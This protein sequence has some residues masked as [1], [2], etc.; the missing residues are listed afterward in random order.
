[1]PISKKYRF[2]FINYTIGCSKF[3]RHIKQ[4]HPNNF[5]GLHVCL[6]ELF[7]NKFFPS[8]WLINIY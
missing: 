5:T 6:L 4:K 8:I 7:V 3:F 1:M 2:Y